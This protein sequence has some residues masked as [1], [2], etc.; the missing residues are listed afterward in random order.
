VRRLLVTQSDLR[1]LRAWVS[2]KFRPERSEDMVERMSTLKEA[3]ERAR[4]RTDASGERMGSATASISEL[5][6]RREKP[7]EDTVPQVHPVNPPPHAPRAQPPVK[8]PE[9]STE[10]GNIGAR[11]LKKRRDREDG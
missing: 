3:R 2:N 7:A 9:P 8:Q 1:R 4:T 11:L 5:R 10:T 6:Q